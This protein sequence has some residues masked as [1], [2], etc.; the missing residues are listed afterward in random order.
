MT[1]RKEQP[2]QAV[3]IVSMQVT[4]PAPVAP[5]APLWWTKAIALCLHHHRLPSRAIPCVPCQKE[6]TGQR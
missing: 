3:H 1:E 6:A 4:E 5:A 2:E